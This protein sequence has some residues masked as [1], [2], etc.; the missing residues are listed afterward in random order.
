MLRYDLTPAAH[1][2]LWEESDAEELHALIE[3][4]R[5]HLA[6]WLPFADQPFEKTRE[7]VRN[8]RR[9]IGERQLLTAIV[10]DGRIVGS[11]G[12]DGIGPDGHST[13]LG[14]WLAADAT[15]R[16]LATR[17]ARAYVDHC[18]GTWRLERVSIRI[19]TGNAPSRRVAQRLGFTHEG[20]LRHQE[21]VAG[22]WQD[23]AIYGLLRNEWAAA[24][25]SSPPPGAP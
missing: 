12:T 16:G 14:Y 23:I 20:T 18:F 3:A 22:A 25:A 15:G 6:P 24:T 17:A 1:L 13:G 7:F 4:N 5:D 19:A 2:R 10:E 8:A 11:I 9:A 21:R